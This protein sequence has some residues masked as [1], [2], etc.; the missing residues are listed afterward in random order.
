MDR[1]P[2]PYWRNFRKQ[3]VTLR[4]PRLG[5]FE[6]N[7]DFSPAT[8]SQALTRPSLWHRPC[9]CRRCAAQGF[10]S[11][12]HDFSISCWLHFVLHCQMLIV[13]EFSSSK[14]S[15]ECNVKSVESFLAKCFF[16]GF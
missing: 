9:S 11:G 3:G 8:H 6:C 5:H 7:R 10:F 16:K 14:P 4:I 2:A 12:S 13:S 15:F 1:N